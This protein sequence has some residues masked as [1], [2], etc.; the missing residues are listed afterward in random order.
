MFFLWINI[1]PHRITQT[2]S[3]KTYACVIESLVMFFN[4]FHCF[5]N[6][7]AANVVSLHFQDTQKSYKDTVYPI[8]SNLSTSQYCN[9]RYSVAWNIQQGFVA[10][11]GVMLVGALWCERFAP[12]VCFW[13]LKAALSLVLQPSAT[14]KQIWM[15]MNDQNIHSVNYG[16]YLQDI[17]DIAWY[18]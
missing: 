11:T 12:S 7:L 2:H 9:F 6:T 4:V 8:L 3:K 17:K 15:I 16:S 5:S 18:N 14:W 13:P 10:T 1:Y